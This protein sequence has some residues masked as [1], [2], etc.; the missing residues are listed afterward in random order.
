MGGAKVRFTVLGPVA[1]EHDGRPLEGAS[2]RHRAVLAYLLLHAGTVIGMERL[3]GAIWGIDAPGTARSQVHAAVT[4]LRRVLRAAPDGDGVLVTRGAGYLVKLEPGSLDL[5]R[6]TAH[7]AEARTI[8]PTDPAAAVEAL[9][10]G[11]ALWRGLPLADVNG[12]FVADARHRLEERRLSAVEQLAEVELGRG[13]HE[14]LIDELAAHVS[15]HPLRERLTGHLMLALYRSGRQADALTEARTL[16]A[17]LAEAQGLDPGRAFTDLEARILRDDPALLLVP[18]EE[19]APAAA[20]PAPPRLSH[21]P[22]AVPDFTGRRDELAHLERIGA[23]GGVVAIDGMAGSGK[24]SFAVHAARRMAG[25]FPDGQLWVD[26]DAHTAGREPV[27]PGA[28]LEVLLRQL[29][30]PS[31]RVPQDTAGRS[32]LWRAELSGRRILAVLDNAASAAQVRPL[33]PDGPGSLVLIT[34]RRR[35][36]DLD[37]AQALSL[38]PL[39]PQDAEALFTGIVGERAA[40]EPLAVLDVLQLCGFLPLAVRIAAARLHHRPKWT[41]GQ[42]AAR[43]RDQRRRLSE[44]TAGDRSVAAAFAL[45]YQQLSAAQQRM[46]RLAGLHPGRDFDATSAAALADLPVEDADV[47]LEDLLDAHMLMQHEADRYTFHDLLRAHARSSAAE[48][49]PAAE[50]EAAVARLL[51]HQLHTTDVAVNLVFPGMRHLLPAVRPSTAGPS[52]LTGTG[53]ALAWLDAERANLLALDG[54]PH[55][56]VGPLAA[57]LSPYLFDYGH[58]ADALALDGRARVLARE[59]GD[60]PSEAR[61]T[62]GVAW[63]R[64]RR[65]D[66]ATTRLHAERALELYRA[67]GDR[68]G[69]ARSLN[70]LGVLCWREGDFDPSADWFGRALELYRAS[71]DGVGETHALGNLALALSGRGELD[72]ADEHLRLALDRYGAMGDG[73]GLEAA[74]VLRQLAV[75]RLRRGLA[76]EAEEV[77][78]EAL[79]RFRRLGNRREEADALNAFGEAALAAGDPAR[80]AR[81]HEAVLELARAHDF[82]GAVEVERARRGLASALG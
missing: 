70:L 80:A 30:V 40:A 49:E 48:C 79:E 65:G 31:G 2:P 17:A 64:L 25:R 69:Q 68:H 8:A 76:A 56:H 39:V 52:P 71:G 5:D 57:L 74:I 50:R 13:R 75:V 59:A 35:L 24:T 77:H 21:L 29:G 32:A 20:D 12:D 46:F 37:A 19:P 78:A 82:D 18:R 42:L 23:P 3:I 44:L 41:I 15:Q 73:D 45:S 81:A 55:A 53:D 1:M 36:M 22:S 63:V 51:L 11:L 67:S 28:A 66:Y 54:A 58:H 43:L 16:R 14:P 10:A 62:L 38:D 27:E 4:A 26:L 6:F 72:A 34:G 60:G 61:S 7:V 9:R 47:L 33:L